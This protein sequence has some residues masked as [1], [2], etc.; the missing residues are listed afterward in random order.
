MYIQ[1]P[2][3]INYHVY[4]KDAV[5]IQPSAGVYYGTSIA[6]SVKSGD[7]KYDMFGDQS[8]YRRSDLA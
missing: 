5:T 2:L 4:I 1:I 8:G 6:G 7:E 3:L